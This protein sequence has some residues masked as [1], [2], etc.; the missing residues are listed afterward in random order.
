MGYH[1]ASK[2]DRSESAN[3]VSLHVVSSEL[4]KEMFRIKLTNNSLLVDLL[5]IQRASG[6]IRVPDLEVDGVHCAFPRENR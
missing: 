1:H 3:L 6:T 2:E 4:V 5:D